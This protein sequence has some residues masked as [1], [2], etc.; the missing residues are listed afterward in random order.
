L[1]RGWEL[2]IERFFVLGEMG[3]VGER[4]SGFALLLADRLLMLLLLLVEVLRRREW[5]RWERGTEVEERE[6]FTDFTFEII[7]VTLLI[8][9]YDKNKLANYF[10]NFNSACRFLMITYYC[11][12]VLCICYNS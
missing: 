8:N 11:F 4:L 2:L 5:L 1:P 3:V 9:H 12:Y 7:K 6:P 10:W